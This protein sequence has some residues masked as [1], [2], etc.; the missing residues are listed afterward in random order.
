MKYNKHIK[1]DKIISE[2]LQYHLDYEIPLTE[3][4]YRPLS[5]NFFK[6]INEVRDLYNQGMIDLNEDDVEIV[7]SE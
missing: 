3:N 7:K 5:Q 6:L 4:V 2:G 1:N